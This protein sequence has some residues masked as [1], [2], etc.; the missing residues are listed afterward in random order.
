V[1]DCINTKHG[2]IFDKLLCM[3]CLTLK[4]CLANAIHIFFLL[5]NGQKV[6][7]VITVTES[8]EYS[9]HRSHFRELIER[10]FLQ[11]LLYP[12]FIL[13]ICLSGI[14]L[15][16]RNPQMRVDKTRAEGLLF[17]FFEVINFVEIGLTIDGSKVNL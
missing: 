12:F 7:V 5:V 9:R 17:F 1:F 16:H 15:G 8:E 2:C 6:F 4:N 13:L 11:K 3:I 14:V 10:L